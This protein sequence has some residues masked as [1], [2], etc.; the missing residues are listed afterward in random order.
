MVCWSV[1]SHESGAVE[2][3]HYGQV[4]YGGVV[5]DVVVGSLRERAVYVA[6]RYESVL[7]H[8]AREGH[9][10]PLGYAH[11]ERPVRHR[12][13]HDVHGASCGHGGRHPHYA[14]IVLGKAQ[15]R[16]PEHVLIARRAPCGHGVEPLSRLGVEL[17]R[18]VPYGGFLLGRL[19]SLAFG[20]VEMQQFWTL[21]VFQLAQ[22]AHHLRHVVPVE[23]T[24]VAYVHSLEDVLLVAQRRLQRVVEPYDA[25]SPVVVEIALGVQPARHSVSQSVVCGVGVEVEQILLHSPHGA[26]NGHVVVVE[27]D[28]QVVWRRRHVVDALEGESSAHCPVA[29]HSH[30][31]A[32]VVPRLLRRHSHAERSRD[33]VGGV[34][35]RECVV[36]AL[37]RRGERAQPFQF[38]VGAEAVSPSG[39]NLVSVCLM[40]HIPHYAVVRRVEDVVQSHGELHHSERRGEVSGVDR[41]FVYDVLAQF[42]AQFGQLLHAEVS[43][44]F[45]ISYA[46]EEPQLVLVHLYQ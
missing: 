19:I 13:H 6:E 31:M 21:H 24:E 16:L 22:Q 26:V 23:R 38:T 10:V 28:E 8:S 46:A 17:P 37:K 2:T 15:E 45:R 7:S 34:S 36:F 40:A 43:Q 11:V 1:L 12:L 42:P 35:A 41:Q 3:E 20:G 18:R 4:E 5:Y 9:G 29:Y 25:F 44:V 32:V 27:D 30:H 33:G 39:E 14:R